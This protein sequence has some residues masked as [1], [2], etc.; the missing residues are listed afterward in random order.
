MGTKLKENIYRALPVIWIFICAALVAV[1]SPRDYIRQFPTGDSTYFMY[2]GKAM[3]EGLTMYKGAWDSKGPFLFFLNYLGMLINETWGI[4]VIRIIFSL[5]FFAVLYKMLMYIS[6]NKRQSCLV[7]FV[8]MLMLATF[9][10]EGNLT[11]EYSLPMITLSL[12][13][14]LQYFKEGETE[15]YKILISGMLCGL[16]F[17]LRANM[18]ITWAIFAAAIFIHLCCTREFA[19]LFKYILAFL[20][21]VVLSFLPFLI[22]LIANDCL[23]DAWYAS[24]LYNILY[25]QT[26]SDTIYSMLKWVYQYL[27]Q[28]GYVIVLFLFLLVVLNKLL[29]KKGDFRERFFAVVYVIYIIAAIGSS[30]MSFRQ[31]Q[32]Y[33]MGLIPAMSIPGIV[34]VQKAENL[35]MSHLKYKQVA[36]VSMLIIT[37]G[38]NFIGIDTIKN[39]IRQYRQIPQ[40]NNVYQEVGEYI[41]ANTDPTDTIYSHRMWGIMYLTADRLSATNYF[42]LAAVNVDEFTEISDGLFEDLE[43]NKPAYIVTQDGRISGE[44]TDSRLQEYITDHYVLEK[45]FDLGIHLYKR[46]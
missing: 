44:E 42:A 39:N 45:E 7:M 4:I 21:G 22:Y 40:N 30:C 34:V 20:S 28:F 16:T 9:I 36:I 17:L 3:K 37:L 11:E 26:S 27:S 10:G 6:N 31:Y 43:S 18:I 32:H 25:S 24:I 29:Y 23:Y 2:I 1:A 8:L 5:A 13:Y 12:F 35:L 41:K 15:W 33:L 38:L 14:F 46:V 19:K